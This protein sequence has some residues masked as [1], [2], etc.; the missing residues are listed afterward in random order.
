MTAPNGYA[1]RY[2]IKG[3]PRKFRNGSQQLQDIIHLLRREAVLLAEEEG[4][5]KV[6]EKIRCCRKTIRTGKPDGK[7]AASPHC[8]IRA[9]DRKRQT[10]C[11]G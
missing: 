11:N 9:A 2:E 10:T 1:V 4:I 6:A 7:R 5:E 8:A 3:E